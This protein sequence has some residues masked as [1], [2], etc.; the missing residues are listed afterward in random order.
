MLN[1]LS[2]GRSRAQ[3]FFLWVSYRGR[4][5]Q[6]AQLFP[7]QKGLRL[8]GL[9]P[10]CSGSSVLGGPQ[11][12]SAQGCCL[13]PGGWGEGGGPHLLWQ[14]PWHWQR[15]CPERRLQKTRRRAITWS[16]SPGNAGPQLGQ[17]GFA[18]RLLGRRSRSRQLPGLKCA[19]VV[20]F[21]SEGPERAG[22]WGSGHHLR[23]CPMGSLR[24]RPSEPRTRMRSPSNCQSLWTPACPQ[25]GRHSFLHIVRTKRGVLPIS[26]GRVQGATAPF[27]PRRQCKHRMELTEETRWEVPR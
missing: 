9:W 23:V 4:G 6:G 10:L 11:P 26:A 2:Q 19:L 24:E 21:C 15:L 27:R 25:K 17:P 20:A 8:G 16:C 5:R 12:I 7:G 14:Y 3:T 22:G 18:R 13:L 1:Q